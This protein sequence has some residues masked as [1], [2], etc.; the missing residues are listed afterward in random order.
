MM[1]SKRRIFYGA[2][3]MLVAALIL[4]IFDGRLGPVASLALVGTFAV[5]SALFSREILRRCL[6]QNTK[7]KEDRHER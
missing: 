4:A 2:A 7:P 6:E 3:L 1:E 5:G